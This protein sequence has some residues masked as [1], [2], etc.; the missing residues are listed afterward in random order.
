MPLRENLFC[1]HTVSKNTCTKMLLNE[2]HC[3]KNREEKEK[4]ARER[5]KTMK[6]RVAFLKQSGTL[7]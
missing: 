5:K 3:E 6:R 2:T 7:G 4:E 1:V